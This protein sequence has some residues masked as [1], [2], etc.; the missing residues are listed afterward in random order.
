MKFPTY[1][2]ASYGR[3]LSV[4]NSFKLIFFYIHDVEVKN[5]INDKSE[6]SLDSDQHL[7]ADVSDKDDSC[8]NTT[9]L[10]PSFNNFMHKHKSPITKHTAKNQPI[11]KK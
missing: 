8:E 6:K 5:V 1:S 3:K 2:Q 9:D 4:Q 7:I 11:D 10:F